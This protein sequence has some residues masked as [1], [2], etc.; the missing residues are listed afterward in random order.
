[1]K[2]LSLLILTVALCASLAQAGDIADIRAGLVPEGTV[3]TIEGA[4]VTAV[5]NSS[6]TVSELPGGPGM[7]LW[8]ITSGPPTVAVGD[9][10]DLFGTY[11]E[12]NERSTFSLWYPA[13]ASITVT[14]SGTP[15][16]IFATADELVADPEAWESTVV[17][18]TDGLIV[19]EILADGNWSV[20]S[21]ETGTVLI[22]ND[23][24]GLFP[25]VALGECYNNAFGVFFRFEGQHVLKALEVEITDCSVGNDTLDFGELKSFFR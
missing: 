25:M 17:M 22:L 4:I 10:V 16:M 12:H 9:I 7:S 11:I 2:K 14:G 8:V 5:M 6:I 18:V 13:E 21:F 15:P 23:Y 19:Q 24:F 1:M 3:L 20:S